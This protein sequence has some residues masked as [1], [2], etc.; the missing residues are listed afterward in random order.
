MEMIRFGNWSVSPFGIEWKGRADIFYSL[1]LGEMLQTGVHNKSILFQWLVE[2]ARDRR[3][4]AEDIYSLNTAFFYSLD[5]FRSE[6]D[7]PCY[8]LIAE[9]LKAKKENMELGE[10]R[11]LSGY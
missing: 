2:I 3:L 4:T 8:V 7:I 6:I 10:A 9:T 5:M 1:T 11:Q